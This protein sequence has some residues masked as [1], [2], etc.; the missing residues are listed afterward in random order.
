MLRHTLATL[1]YRGGKALRDAPEVFAD[2]R[3]GETSR[4]PKEILAHASDVLDWAL[5]MARGPQAWQESKQLSWGD[6][7]DR[8]FEALR[9]LDD[10]LASDSSL[11][12]PEEKIFQGPIADALT[13]V[14][15]LSMLRRLAGSPIK[16][17][18]YFKAN[19]ETGVVGPDQPNPVREFD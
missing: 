17:E 3:V 11:G 4:S 5:T 14:G 10:Y 13:H 8:F 6:E 18:N 9:A 1:A 2:Y 12:A 19:I 16:G 15:Q 7:V